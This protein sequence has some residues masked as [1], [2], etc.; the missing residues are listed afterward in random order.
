R[1]RRRGARP[2]LWRRPRRPAG[3]RAGVRGR[4]RRAARRPGAP[5]SS[6]GRRA[7]R[8]RGADLGRGSGGAPRGIPGGRVIFRKPFGDLIER[9]LALFERENADLLR[10][11]AAA[12]RD[13]DRAERDEAEE[14][15]S[16]FLDLV[17]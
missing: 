9:Q 8:P 6:A 15:Y 3:R 2:P 14:R 17:E 5:G 11:L 4:G 7:P 12:E 13:Y 10:T 1:R 16:I